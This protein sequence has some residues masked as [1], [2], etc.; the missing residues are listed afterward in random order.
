[1]NLTFIVW[2]QHFLLTLTMKFVHFQ[3]EISKKVF[4]DTKSQSLVGVIFYFHFL[5]GK[6]QW[7]NLHCLTNNRNEKCHPLI[8]TRRITLIEP[9]II[10]ILICLT[11]FGYEACMHFLTH[12]LASSSYQN[13]RIYHSKWICYLSQFILFKIFG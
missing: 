9:T 13:H 3:N 4:G 11:Y 1:M 2:Y 10:I 8:Q 12:S 6:N 5:N 7:K